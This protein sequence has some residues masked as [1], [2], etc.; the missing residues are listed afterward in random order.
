[1]WCQ[2]RKANLLCSVTAFV[3]GLGF[4]SLFSPSQAEKPG[5]VVDPS[6]PAESFNRTSKKCFEA[7]AKELPE[8]RETERERNLKDAIADAERKLVDVRLRSKIYSETYEEQRKEF[9][10]NLET[11]IEELRSKL[12]SAR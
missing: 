12:E 6:A 3:I 11:R 1:M 5:L 9:Q 10:L 8:F 2:F 7:A 4:A